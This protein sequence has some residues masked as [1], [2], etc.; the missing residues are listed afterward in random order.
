MSSWAMCGGIAG[1][2][3]RGMPLSAKMPDGMGWGGMG[4]GPLSDGAPR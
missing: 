2:V 3:S 4:G 1:A